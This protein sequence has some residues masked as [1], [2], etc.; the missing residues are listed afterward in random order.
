LGATN[1]CPAAPLNQDG[2]GLLGAL[3]VEPADSYWD[4]TGYVSPQAEIYA[5]KTKDKLLFHDFVLVQQQNSINLSG[6]PPGKLSSGRSKPPISSAVNNRSEDL[7]FRFALGP[8]PPVPWQ[9]L[10][11][12]FNGSDPKT[13][14]FHAEQGDH[15]RFRV[16]QAGGDSINQNIMFEIHGHS[17]Q[18]EPWIKS[19]SELGDNQE[20][21]VLGADILVPHKAL[22]ILIDSAGGPQG[23]PGDYL[24]RNYLAG[25]GAWGIFRVEKKK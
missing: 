24:Y 15:V 22:N 23:V 6:K 8:N 10:S 21:N 2:N 25:D 16:L 3:I 7:R 20:S 12:S 4:P 9:V 19:S 1:L 5:S 18:Q 17:W 13:P 14:I 11:N